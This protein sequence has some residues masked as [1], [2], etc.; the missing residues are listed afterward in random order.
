MRVRR[1]CP[2][3]K[4]DKLRAL[5][6]LQTLL[7]RARRIRIQQR[8]DKHKLYA[9]HAAQVQCIS[10]DKARNPYELG[11]KVRLA[12]T[13]KHAL[14]VGARSW[15]GNPYDAHLLSAQWEQT[16]HLVQDLGQMP[17]QAIV[18]RGYRGVDADNP[19]VE[20]IQRGKYKSLRKLHRHLLKLRQAI[21]ALIAYVA[22]SL[23]AISA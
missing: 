14:M 4:A 22:R 11:V 3:V 21:E 10:K 1:R 18:E 2:P 23:R 8:H 5:S 12:L 13:H 6:G 7:E 15:P 19:G 20:I 16:T 9:L 17:Q